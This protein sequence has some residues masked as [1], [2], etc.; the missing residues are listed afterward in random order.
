MLEI[1]NQRL[2]DKKDPQRTY[3][4]S[5]W[6]RMC[7]LLKK[8]FVVFLPRVIPS[9]FA[10]ATLNPETGVQ[11]FLTS[12]SITDVLQEAS[13]NIDSTTKIN[14]NTDET[15][16]KDVAIQML[17]VFIDELEGGFA[18][19]IEPTSKILLSLVDYALND[20]IRTS[21]AGS[22]PGLVKCAKDARPDDK[23][24]LVAMGKTYLEALVNALNQEQETEAR[25]AQ[26][27]AIK[28]VIDEVGSGFFFDPEQVN[29]LAK[30]GLDQVEESDKRIE[31]NNNMM[32]KQDGDDEDDFDE[33]DEKLVKEEN[34][35]EY[36]LQLSVAELIGILFKTH[37]QLCGP[38]IDGLFAKTLRETV[39]SPIKQKKKFALFILDDMVE[40]LGQGIGAKFSDVSQALLAFAVSPSPALR[41]AS[42]YGIGLM[43]Q[44]CGPLFASVSGGALQQ[45]KTA[46]EIEKPAKD[47]VGKN[48]EKQWRHARDNAISALGKIIRYQSQS[49]DTNAVVPSW[50]QLMPIVT[51]QEEAKIQ[52]DIF[53]DLLSSGPELV[54]GANKERLNHCVSIIAEL[55]SP[56]LST[57]ESRQKLV[58]L[59]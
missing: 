25:V 3:L 40:F 13:T 24:T 9:L 42:V 36:E 14:I 51:D 5:A 55:L 32:K 49:I 41:Q 26:I 52:G 27:Q 10:L 33:D 28:D 4:L 7:L 23:A 50:V 1:Q 29:T 37:A 17:A 18:D 44:N 16:E 53:A 30:L 21:V 31:E 39:S 58:R 34:K 12:A 59:V 2:D 35:G 56:K 11:G 8:D 22:F 47:A 46:I 15:E 45:L 48:K 19:Y 20:S 38:L 54:L 6:Q 43:A 57:D